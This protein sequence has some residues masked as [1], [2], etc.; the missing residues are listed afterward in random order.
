M[1]HERNRSDTKTG[2]GRMPR[3]KS[4]VARPKRR[5][6]IGAGSIHCDVEIL[7][8]STQGRIEEARALYEKHHAIRGAAP[9]KKLALWYAWST[10][11]ETKR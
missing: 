6:A 7:R 1:I 4:A 11:E 5:L 2:P 3:R 8:L 10:P 9:L